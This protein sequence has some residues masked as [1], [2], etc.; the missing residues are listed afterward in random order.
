MLFLL[1]NMS[2]DSGINMNMIIVINS[3]KN[4]NENRLVDVTIYS[5]QGYRLSIIII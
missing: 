4:I 3:S 5:T 1:I 2:G